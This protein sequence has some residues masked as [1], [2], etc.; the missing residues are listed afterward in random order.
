MPSRS[1]RLRG[2]LRPLSWMMLSSRQA[3]VIRSVVGK[4]QQHT[5]QPSYLRIF[6]PLCLDV[7]WETVEARGHGKQLEYHQLQPPIS[8][9]PT[10]AF[11]SLASRQILLRPPLIRSLGCRS[12]LLTIFTKNMSFRQMRSG[13]ATTGR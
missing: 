1:C 11:S 3:A 4:I 5:A 6:F 10:K 9:Q 12:H 8:R 13:G 7:E 2:P